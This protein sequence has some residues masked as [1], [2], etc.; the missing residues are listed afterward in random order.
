M[1]YMRT[2]QGAFAME[3][4]L[5]PS[6]RRA[7]EPG[8][9]LA[10]AGDAPASRTPDVR[11]DGVWERHGVQRPCIPAR[12]RWMGPPRWLLQ[13]RR[14]SPQ[15]ACAAP[16]PSR[17]RTGEATTLRQPFAADGMRGRHYCS[18]A[19]GN[20]HAALQSPHRWRLHL[21]T[22]WGQPCLVGTWARKSR[23]NTRR[24]DAAAGM[25]T[26]GKKQKSALRGSVSLDKERP[27]KGSAPQCSHAPRCLFRKSYASIFWP[28]QRIEFGH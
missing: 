15:G 25:Y 14:G 7:G 3:R 13:R 22:G 23:Q 11:R 20:R 9:S 27:H 4:F 18:G 8:A 12:W 24:D 16:P 6:G 21:K 19:E 2:R 10:P 28:Q 26:A 17:A 1:K 5:Q